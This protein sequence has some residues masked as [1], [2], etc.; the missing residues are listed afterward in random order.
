[1]GGKESRRAVI[2]DANLLA[3]ESQQHR[4]AV[5]RIHIVIDDKNASS[6]Q[7]CAGPGVILSFFIL[8]F[9]HLHRK[10]DDKF[11]SLSEAGAVRFHRA[12][13][14]LDETFH[15]SQTDADASLRT[16]QAS[17][18][19]HKKIEDARKHARRDADAGIPDAKENMPPFLH[20]GQPDRPPGSVYLAALL[21]RLVRICSK[22]VASA[23]TRRSPGG[24]ETTKSCPRS[25]SRGRT[26]STVRFRIAV[27]FRASLRSSIFPRLM[28]D[29]SSRSSKRWRD[30]LHLPLGHVSRLAD[31]LGV[32]A[33]LLHDVQSVA[34][35]RQ[36]VAQL[37]R[38]HCQEFVLQAVGLPQLRIES[39]I[40]DRDGGPS[41]KLF[42]KR[43]FVGPSTSGRTPP[44][45]T[46]TRPGSCRA[47]LS[48]THM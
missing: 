11:T 21:R 42:S 34:Y 33:G 14:K 19:L 6:G 2:S 12:S 36:R 44:R 46:T 39:G 1:M 8:R 24:T 40:L 22:R 48:G 7:T 13:V 37:V 4:N 41:G 29:T 20:R 10:P 15:K 3:N 45:R 43:K 16:I 35:G 9:T 31:H 30:V 5:C 23:S 47:C 17:L 38:K 26:A 27:T 32:C 28:R 25:S 18:N